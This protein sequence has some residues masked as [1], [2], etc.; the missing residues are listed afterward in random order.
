VSLRSTFAAVQAIMGVNVQA[1]MVLLT[2][3]PVQEKPV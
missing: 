2:P 1:N 3:V